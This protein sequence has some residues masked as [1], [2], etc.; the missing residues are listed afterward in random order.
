[1]EYK[2]LTFITLPFLD[3]GKGRTYSPGEMISHAE[4]E[5]SIETGEAAIGEDSS[6]LS[7]CAGRG[8]CRVCEAARQWAMRPL[9]QTCTVSQ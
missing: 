2:A 9:R 8:C 4:I 6:N 1:M 5:E 7:S 3:D